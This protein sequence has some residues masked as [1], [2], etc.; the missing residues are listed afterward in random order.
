M[1]TASIEKINEEF[2]WIF[3][4]QFSLLK[5]FQIKR[6]PHKKETHTHTHTQPVGF[7][8]PG[9]I[10]KIQTQPSPLPPNQPIFTFR[11]LSL[12]LSNYY[13]SASNKI[14]QKI[15][16]NT[17]LMVCLLIF[18]SQNVPNLLTLKTCVA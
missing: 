18:P 16:C 6:N 2:N 1:Q 9:I 17:L 11:Y 12:D 15:N 7:T 13:L 4:L 8:S 5:C 10:L 3:V 14:Q